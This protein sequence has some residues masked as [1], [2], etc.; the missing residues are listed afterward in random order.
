MARAGVYTRERERERER[1]RDKAAT[2]ARRGP[3]QPQAPRRAGP[4]S[5]PHKL[6]RGAG[7]HLPNKRFFSLLALFFVGGSVAFFLRCIY[8]GYRVRARAPDYWRLP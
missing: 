6:P 2:R 1:E 7:T 4:D 8:R 5:L 3:R